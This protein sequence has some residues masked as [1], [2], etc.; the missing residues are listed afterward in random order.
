[1]SSR[2]TPIY[3]NQLTVDSIPSGGSLSGSTVLDILRVVAANSTAQQT[4]VESG[5]F[6]ERGIA[7][8]TYYIKIENI[9]TGAVTGVIRAFWSEEV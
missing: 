5:T 9:G 2:P 4:I 8:G 6:N 7:A 3:T 1:M